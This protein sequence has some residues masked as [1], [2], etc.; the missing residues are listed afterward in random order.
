MVFFNDLLFSLESDVDN[1][2]DDTTIT[3][4]AKSV[5]EIRIKLTS[6]CKKISN[7]MKSNLLKLNPEK[8]M[9]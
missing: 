6:D 3:S 1:Y 8:L 2:A 9:S 4:T 7:W 5:D